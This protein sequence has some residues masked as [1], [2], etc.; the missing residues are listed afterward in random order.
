MKIFDYV[1]A[2]VHV[3]LTGAVA[4]FAAVPLRTLV[5]VELSIHGGGEMGR[6]AKFV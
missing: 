2:A 4:G 3:L 5:R 1:A 6:F